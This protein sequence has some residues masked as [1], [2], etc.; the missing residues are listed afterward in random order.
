MKKPAFKRRR[1]KCNRLIGANGLGMHRKSCKPWQKH[2]RAMRRRASSIFLD[3][4]Q[5]GLRSW[6]HEPSP[7]F[8][9]FERERH[10]RKFNINLRDR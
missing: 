3:A 10:G 5:D 2:L 1:C 4:Y 8:A 9:A 7:V 6:F